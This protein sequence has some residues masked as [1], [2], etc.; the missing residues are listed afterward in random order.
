MKIAIIGS[1]GKAGHAIVKEAMQRGIDITG[2]SRG[3]NKHPGINYIKC[4]LFDLTQEILESYDVVINA[5]GT[6]TP[7]TLH[8][9]KVSSDYLSTIL[10]GLNTRLIIVG[11]AGSLYLDASLTTQL[12]DTP[13]FPEDYKPLADAMGEAL[14]LIRTRDDVL[15]TY[16]S[17][18]VIFDANGKRTGSYELS[19]EVLT[20]NDESKSYISYADFA[21]AVIDEAI[22][23]THPQERISVYTK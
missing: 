1:N 19:G 5:F 20:F 7:E 12:K 18:A 8:L 22:N 21:I 2:Y 3:D 17:P 13:D 16:I 4:D 15:W 6:W 9:H 23:A 11:G 14:D 10:S